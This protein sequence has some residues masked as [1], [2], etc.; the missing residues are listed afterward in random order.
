MYCRRMPR[1]LRPRTCRNRL[2][3]CGDSVEP[4]VGG[5]WRRHW[6]CVARR[7]SEASRRSSFSNRRERTWNC[8]GSASRDWAGY[9]PTC[10]WRHTSIDCRRG[11]WWRPQRV[12]GSPHRPCTPFGR[13]AAD[14]Y[15]QGR[16]SSTARSG[17]SA[18]ALQ[19]NTPTRGTCGC[20]W[21][22]ERAPDRRRRFP[23]NWRFE[24]HAGEQ[25]S[26]STARRLPKRGKASPWSFRASIEREGFDRRDAGDAAAL[27]R[28]FA[29][30]D[31]SPPRFAASERYVQRVLAGRDSDVQPFAAVRIEGRTGS[32]VARLVAADD[33]AQVMVC[34]GPS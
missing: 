30:A 26:T 19:S 7:S 6:T 10:R 15:R 9:E 16:R 23:W 33:G 25:G 17:Q 20:R 12:R 31:I 14:G 1:S 2:P 29:A 5:W 11:R 3:A 34:T 13:S 21:P 32:A 24:A 18:A 28:L 27:R 8:W 22:K 4:A